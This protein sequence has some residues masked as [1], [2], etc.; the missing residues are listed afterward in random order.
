MHSHNYFNANEWKNPQTNT[1][2]C[3]TSRGNPSKGA[4][5]ISVS[6]KSVNIRTNTYKD[7]RN[8]YIAN[9]VLME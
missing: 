9:S 6:G 3:S 2:C 1:A 5:V 4:T 8:T 7:E